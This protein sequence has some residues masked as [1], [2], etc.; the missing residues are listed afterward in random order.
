MPASLDHSPINGDARGY[1]F[2]RWDRYLGSVE[3]DAS[4]PSALRM[5]LDAHE[6]EPHPTRYSHRF[7]RSP[8]SQLFRADRHCGFLRLAVLGLNIDRD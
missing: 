6:Q 1:D 2:P 4:I 3:I 8:R 7:F 5:R